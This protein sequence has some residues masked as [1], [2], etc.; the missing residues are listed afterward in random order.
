MN[1]GTDLILT[2]SQGSAP[3]IPSSV[4]MSAL[5]I[6]SED[7]V[8]AYMNRH[9]STDAQR[10]AAC[11]ILMEEGMSGA[12]RSGMLLEQL[13]EYSKRSEIWKSARA[14]NHAAFL[15]K[16]HWDERAAPIVKHSRDMTEVKTR[17][18]GR[19]VA[20]WGPGDEGGGWLEHLE[21]WR[22]EHMSATH[23]ETLAAHAKKSISWVDSRRHLQAARV[24]RRDP[25]NKGQRKEDPLTSQDI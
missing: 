25:T 14:P 1:P 19:I 5:T 2:P 15:E 21:K 8:A 3:T 22:P 13:M 24:K 4:D 17:S 12:E 16:L 18:V 7:G 11:I 9:F 23:L 20:A 6:C 10:A